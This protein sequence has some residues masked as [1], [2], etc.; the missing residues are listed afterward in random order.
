MRPATAGSV[1]GADNSGHLVKTGQHWIVTGVRGQFQDRS[2]Q[3]TL[4][5]RPSYASATPKRVSVSSVS[6]PPARK[7][8]Y[9]FGLR[10]APCFVRQ[11]S[12]PRR[13]DL[14]GRRLTPQAPSNSRRTQIQAVLARTTPGPRGTQQPSRPCSSSTRSSRRLPSI[15]CTSSGPLDAGASSPPGLPFIGFRVI[16]PSLVHRHPTIWDRAV[17]GIRVRSSSTHVPNAPTNTTQC[18]ARDRREK[19]Q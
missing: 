13:L 17:Q 11:L 16:P 4:E 7:E 9:S 2:D 10:V 6:A 15:R 5:V 14:R 8:P 3:W 1:P 12:D 18:A 19:P